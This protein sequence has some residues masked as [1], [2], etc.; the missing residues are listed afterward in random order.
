MEL[1]KDGVGFAHNGKASCHVSMHVLC[2]D[3]RDCSIG[4]LA[5]AIHIRVS[6]LRGLLAHA[7]IIR[8]CGSGTCHYSQTR[9]G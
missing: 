2:V 8:V 1:S 5:H 9:S 3:L 7:S 6:G 4:W